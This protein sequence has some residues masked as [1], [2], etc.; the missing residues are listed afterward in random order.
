M[1]IVKIF[2]YFF[3]NL[4]E[5][6]GAYC[7]FAGGESEIPKMSLVSESTQIFL[8][9]AHQSAQSYHSSTTSSNESVGGQWVLLEPQSPLPPLARFRKTFRLMNMGADNRYF[10]F[11]VLT[12]IAHYIRAPI[13]TVKYSYSTYTVLSISC[14]L[15]RPRPLASRLLA[16]VRRWRAHACG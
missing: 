4:Q 7:D 2:I 8:P 16:A 9:A 14:T 15:Y 6:L 13:H 5:A 10:S 12:V 11:F 3:R 1:Y